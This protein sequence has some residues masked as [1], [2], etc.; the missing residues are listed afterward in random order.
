MTDGGTVFAGHNKTPHKGLDCDCDECDKFNIYVCS[1]LMY[2]NKLG[3]LEDALAES[4][5]NDCLM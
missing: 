5:I 1:D 3:N 2:D 4:L